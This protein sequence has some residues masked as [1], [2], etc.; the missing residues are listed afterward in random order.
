MTV[1]RQWPTPHLNV[2]AAEP[3]ALPADAGHRQNREFTR[4]NAR[5][6]WAGMSRW[7][8]ARSE[9]RPDLHCTPGLQELYKLLQ[10]FRV[11]SAGLLALTHAAH[12]LRL[13]VGCNR[14][15]VG[16]ADS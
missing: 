7:T 1:A 8:S 14:P 4:R 16:G 9:G 3:Q 15:S 10:N 5:V 12:Q 6:S 2:E 11:G 13:S